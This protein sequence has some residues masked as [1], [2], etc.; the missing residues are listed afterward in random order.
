MNP[1]TVGSIIEAVARYCITTSSALSLLLLISDCMDRIMDVF[2]V[3]HVETDLR[4]DPMDDRRREKPPTI[5]RIYL[6][7]TLQFCINGARV[8]YGKM[9]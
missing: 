4:A 3:T 7:L 9:C 2:G 5:I 6:T 8:D 1:A